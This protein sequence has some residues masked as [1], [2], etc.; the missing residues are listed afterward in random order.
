MEQTPSL[1]DVF[2]PSTE[3]RAAIGNNVFILKT[4][5]ADVLVSSHH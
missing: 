2:A 5:P 4:K 1:T 3:E